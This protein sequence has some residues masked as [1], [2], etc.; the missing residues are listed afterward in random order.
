MYAIRSYYELKCSPNLKSDNWNNPKDFQWTAEKGF[1]LTGTKAV[2][3]EPM[4]NM[5]RNNF[6]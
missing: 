3:G 2:I 1:Q 4:G 6:V 5:A